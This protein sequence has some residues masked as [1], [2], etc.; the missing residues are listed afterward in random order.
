MVLPTADDCVFCAFLSGLRPYTILERSDTVALLVTREQR[1]IG[2]LLAIPTAHRPTMLD[3]QP[4]E[5]AP[6]L[7]LTQRATAAIVQAFDVEGVAVWQNNGV[8]ARQ[9]VPH[10]HFHVAGTLPRGGTD[11]GEVPRLSVAETDDI[12]ERLR[13]HL[14]SAGP[15]SRHDQRAPTSSTT[16]TR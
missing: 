8:S 9:S 4:D 5:F 13:P 12:A 10:L 7:E 15:L 14:T 1:G 11:W 6:L 16:A 3:L 2:H